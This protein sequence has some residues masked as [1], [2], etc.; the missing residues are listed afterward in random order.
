MRVAAVHD[1]ER[2]V[3]QFSQKGLTE[4]WHNATD[5]WMCGE[6]FDVLKN[7]GHEP[8]TDLRY[9]LFRIPR[10]DSFQIA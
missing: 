9:A 2:R 1:A 6:R 8:F 4:L 10:P 7:L 3:N 5:V